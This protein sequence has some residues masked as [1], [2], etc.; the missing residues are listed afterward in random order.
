MATEGEK[1]A[2]PPPLAVMLA[3]KLWN[4]PVFLSM[5]MV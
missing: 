3:T 4:R 2:R 1:L 5:A